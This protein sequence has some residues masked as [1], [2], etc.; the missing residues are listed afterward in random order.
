MYRVIRKMPQ[1]IFSEYDI[2]IPYSHWLET[3]LEALKW[4]TERGLQSI[5]YVVDDCKYKRLGGVL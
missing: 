4:M 5:C 3:R 2:P 1:I